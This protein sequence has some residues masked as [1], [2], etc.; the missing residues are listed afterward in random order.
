MTECL[1]CWVTYYLSRDDIERRED[2]S[3][4]ASIGNHRLYKLEPSGSK[5]V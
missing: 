2:R 1:C 5:Y 3:A 4:S